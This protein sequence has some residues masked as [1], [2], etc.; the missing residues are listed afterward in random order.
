MTNIENMVDTA[1]KNFIA[2]AA[3]GTAYFKTQFN[4]RLQSIKGRPR[5]ASPLQF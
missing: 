3:M 2:N 4:I 5:N 1:Q